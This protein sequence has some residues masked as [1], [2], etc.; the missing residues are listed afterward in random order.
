MYCVPKTGT[1]TRYEIILEQHLDLYGHNDDRVLQMAWLNSHHQS[2]I[3]NLMDRAIIHFGGDNPAIAGLQRYRKID[4]LPFDFERHRLSIVVADEN[5]QQTLICKGAVDEMLAVSRYWME[6]DT[7][8]E[9]D[10]AARAH[11]QQQV[12]QYNQQG[13]RVLLVAKRHLDE[14][15]LTAP[16]CADDERDLVIL[17]LLT[18]LD[19]PKESAAEAIRAL[20]ENGVSV[21]VLTGDNAVITGKICRDVG[22]TPGTPLCGWDIARLDDDDELACAVETTTVFCR[23]TP[24]QK[25][26]VV[27]ALQ[28]NAHTVGFLGDGINDTPALHYSDI[29]IS[30]DS[31]ADI[32]KESADII[33]LEKKLLVLEKGLSKAG[34]PLA[35]SSNT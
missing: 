15:A 18:F 6:G 16:L 13:F 11:W 29:G 17:G 10:Q 4:E 5:G 1:L 28:R 14:G 32:A 7:R 19:P 31:A 3:K 30:V 12:E 20:Q 23:L 2:G 21:K 35:I 9:L 33:L 22:L 24:Q 8:R 27:Q 26:R 25:S 34:K